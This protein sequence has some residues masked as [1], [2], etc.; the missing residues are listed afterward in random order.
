MKRYLTRLTALALLTLSALSLT[1]AQAQNYPNKT[2]RLIVPTAP[3]GGYDFVGRVLAEK[4]TTELG[5]TMIVENRK[6]KV[7]SV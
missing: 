2:I 4:L 3:G 1:H 5:Q 7:S 6:V